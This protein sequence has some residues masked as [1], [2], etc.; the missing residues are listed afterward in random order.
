MWIALQCLGRLEPL[1]RMTDT[2]SASELLSSVCS[3]QNYWCEG[4]NT[5]SA[6][7]LLSSVWAYQNYWCEGLNMNPYSIIWADQPL[8]WMAEHPS[9]KWLSMDGAD[10]NNWWELLNTIQLVSL[11]S[12]WADQTW[13]VEHP[14]CF[15]AFFYP[16]SQP[17]PLSFRVNIAVQGGKNT[18]AVRPSEGH[19]ST[20]HVQVLQEEIGAERILFYWIFIIFITCIELFFYIILIM[21]STTCK[22]FLFLLL[23]VTAMTLF[24]V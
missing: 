21:M 7:E 18:C 1:M 2:Y 10:Q 12:I 19:C 6:S 13:M 14:C 15:M 20:W 16:A 24:S 5:Y 23:Q 22:L 9:S 3:G 4:L 11:S 17:L 8:T